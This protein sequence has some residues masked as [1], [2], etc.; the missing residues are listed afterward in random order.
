MRHLDEPVAI[1]G[2][3]RTD[4]S[5]QL[6]EQRIRVVFSV[7]LIASTALSAANAPCIQTTE[8]GNCVSPLLTK[9]VCLKRYQVNPDTS[10]DQGFID[11]SIER[12]R[13][14]AAARE[15]DAVYR[16]PSRKLQLN[17]KRRNRS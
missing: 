7:V 2:N 4:D 16:K 1:P 9:V 15:E 3:F 17:N 10:P 11:L 8:M 13:L 6:I 14:F 5:L 12:V